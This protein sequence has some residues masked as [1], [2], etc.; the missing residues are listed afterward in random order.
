MREFN[1][2]IKNKSMM[3]SINTQISSTK[4]SQPLS[5]STRYFLNSIIKSKARSEFYFPSVRDN[6]T[7]YLLSPCWWKW[8]R[9]LC[10]RSFFFLYSQTW[11][12]EQCLL[13]QNN[14]VGAI[15]LSLLRKIFSWQSALLKISQRFLWWRTNINRKRLQNWQLELHR[16]KKVVSHW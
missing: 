6:H 10:N 9:I 15:H 8:E 5:N 3:C 14:F 4:S 12:W 11:E 7:Y 13:L 2:K 16:C 1:H